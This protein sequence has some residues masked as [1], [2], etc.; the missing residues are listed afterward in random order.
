MIV[1]EFYVSS[2]SPEA[3]ET[4]DTLARKLYDKSLSEE[5]VS[6]IKLEMSRNLNLIMANRNETLAEATRLYETV[7]ILCRVFT[8][9]RRT[10]HSI[11]WTTPLPSLKKTSST[12]LQHPISSQVR[13]LR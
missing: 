2:N 3:V 12:L 6:K 10:K 11:R 8:N 7:P 9:G 4:F 1:V 5:A 13:R